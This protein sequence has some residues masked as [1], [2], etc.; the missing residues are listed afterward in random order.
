[1]GDVGEEL[2]FGAAGGEGLLHGLFE[3]FGALADFIL[4]AD[5]VFVDLV[6]GLLEDVDHGVEAMAEVFDFIA[7]AGDLDGFEAAVAD[8]GDAALE[9]VE[10]FGEEVVGIEGDDAADDAEDDGKEDELAG[11]E[12]VA[13]EVESEVDAGHPSQ[14]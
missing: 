13:H 6:A 7:G 3:L 8:G 5:L 4:E 9:L 2:A 10:G 11:V 1:M 12:L 14:E